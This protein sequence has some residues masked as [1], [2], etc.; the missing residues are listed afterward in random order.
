MGQ[1]QKLLL[2]GIQFTAVSCLTAV[3]GT[4][5]AAD[6]IWGILSIT[7]FIIGVALFTVGFIN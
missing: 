5:P 1:D 6:G 2:A 3:I 7:F 4:E